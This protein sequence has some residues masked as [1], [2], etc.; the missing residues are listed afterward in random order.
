MAYH[1]QAIPPV[2]PGMV[3]VP[4]FHMPGYGYQPP[5]GPFPGTESHMVKSGSNT[6]TQALVSPGNGNIEPP[7]QGDQIPYDSKSFIGRPND[8][9]RSVQSKAAWPNQRP[10]GSKDN[11]Q[12]QPSMGQRPFIRP[13][14]Y[15]HAPAFVD[16]VNFHGN[17][18]LLGSI[19]KWAL[20]CY[21]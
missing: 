2:Y 7:P 11:I 21:K 20:L 12:L 15:G 6:A 18:L 17:F 19:K 1:P 14:F 9:E 5:R 16:G 10:I 8:H 13:P 3:P 4:Q